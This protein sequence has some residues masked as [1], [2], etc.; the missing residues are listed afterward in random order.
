MPYK[1]D[2]YHIC[3]CMYVKYIAKGRFFFGGGRG[4]TIYIYIHILKKGKKLQQPHLSKVR[5]TLCWSD[6]DLV[7]VFLL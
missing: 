7:A 6:Q 5:R 4:G 1:G 3:V 2:V